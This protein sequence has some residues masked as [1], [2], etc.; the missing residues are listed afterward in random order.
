MLH[1]LL[2][3]LL[4]LAGIIVLCGVIIFSVIV[5][6]LFIKYATIACRNETNNDHDGDKS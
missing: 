3:G 6:G 4:E 5:I 2:V 1:Q